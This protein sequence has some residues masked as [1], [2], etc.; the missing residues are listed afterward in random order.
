MKRFA[1]LAYAVLVYLFFFAVFS[2]A[3]GF[4]A[5]AFVPKTI[6]TGGR[7]L[8]PAMALCVDLGLLALFAVQHSLMARPGFKRVWTRI[9]PPAVERATYVLFSS[10]AMLALFVF[11][12]PIPVVVWSIGDPVL[13]AVVHT[14]H[15]GAWGL[16]L[17][18]T[19]MIDHLDLFGVRQALLHFR[20]RPHAKSLFSTP[21]LYRFVRHPIYVAWTLI[22]WTAPTM[23]AGHALFAFLCTAYILL[24]IPLEERDLVREFGDTYRTYRA[25]TPA[26]VP[27]LRGRAARGKAA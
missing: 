20:G 11:W 23:T 26:L 13:R 16:L 10:L 8:A 12:E 17:W 3:I 19:C 4:V 2:Y 14:A 25:S 9:V 22:F 24:A 1:T 5:D 21:V 18:A 6:D 27:G 15:F 7:G